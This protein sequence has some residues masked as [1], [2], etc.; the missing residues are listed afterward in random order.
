MITNTSLMQHNSDTLSAVKHQV[1]E[2]I[3][4]ATNLTVYFEDKK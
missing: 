3:P 2:D 4:S 1:L